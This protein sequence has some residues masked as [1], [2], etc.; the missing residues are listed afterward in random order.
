MVE[1]P[2]PAQ[3]QLDRRRAN[4]HFNSWRLSSSILRSEGSVAL[5]APAPLTRAADTDYVVARHAAL[6]N[7]ITQQP[8][9]CYVFLEEGQGVGQPPLALHQ[10]EVGEAGQ[11][12]Q[13]TRVCGGE[14][15]GA[16]A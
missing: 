12:P 5:P 11:P 4:L 3:L 7:G 6:L 15:L 14:W 1:P 9:A 8:H 2:A 16:L 10:L 13:L